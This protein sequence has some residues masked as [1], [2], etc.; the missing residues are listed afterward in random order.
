MMV[1]WYLPTRSSSFSG[2]HEFSLLMDET[3]RESYSD[4]LVMYTFNIYMYFFVSVL[5]SVLI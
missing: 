2:K 5:L 4:V 1:M 3:E